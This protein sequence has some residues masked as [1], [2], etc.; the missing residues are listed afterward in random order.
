MSADVRNLKRVQTDSFGAPVIPGDVKDRI[1]SL[2][3]MGI[4]K[5]TWVLVLAQPVTYYVH[6]G[7]TV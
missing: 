6:T 2:K 5:S 1:W 3:V 4:V 7:F